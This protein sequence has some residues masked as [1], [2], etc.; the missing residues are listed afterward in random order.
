MRNYSLSENSDHITTNY[1]TVVRITQPEHLE[2]TPQDPTASLLRKPNATHQQALT[3]STS[4]KSKIS[5]RSSVRSSKTAYIRRKGSS[6]TITPATP[7]HLITVKNVHSSLD[8]SGTA[9]EDQ[10]NG[11]ELTE[12]VRVQVLGDS[13]TD[14]DGEEPKMNRVNQQEESSNA[15]HSRSIVSA[16]DLSS[17]LFEE[18]QSNQDIE[19]ENVS[20][21]ILGDSDE[22]NERNGIR[23]H[24]GSSTS[25]RGG[26]SGDTK[27]D[28]VIRIQPDSTFD[29]KLPKPVKQK[30][31]YLR[32]KRRMPP[33]SQ[34]QHISPTTTFTNSNSTLHQ[35]INPSSLSA[36]SK[37]P[38][39][40][41][42]NA[43]FSKD[44][45]QTSRDNLTA[46]N[47]SPMR[48]DTKP[49]ESRKLGKPRESCGCVIC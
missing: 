1:S 17:K 39:T 20:I 41:L 19:N 7:Q 21:V 16:I 46:L 11:Y 33:R 44:N 38:H 30:P 32:K 2:L 31:K 36:V 22:E 8:L 28:I 26:S 14:T 48:M 43:H 5:T 10:E 4:M 6:R 9:I 34:P 15:E 35:D 49:E 40:Q 13:D 3:Y 24:P 27:C 45:I 12:G 23:N 37:D 25:E 42:R 47:N 18:S 29:L